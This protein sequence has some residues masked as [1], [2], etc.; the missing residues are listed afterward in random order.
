LAAQGVDVALLDDVGQGRA[1][2]R[3]QETRESQAFYECLAAMGR[4]SLADLI[5]LARQE[6]ADAAARWR[7]EASEATD[8]NQR[9]VAAALADA[10]RSGLSPVWPMFRRAEDAAG[11]FVLLEGTARRA[12]RIVVDGD[13]APTGLREYYEL[14]LF[15]ADSDHLPV[16][17]CAAR[18]PTGFP[19]GDQ[20]RE[21][22]R[23]A[24]VFFKRWAYAR[25]HSTLPD[26]ERLPERLA[27]PLVIAS[28]PQWLLA[29][30]AAAPQI[31]DVWVG[32]AFAAALAVVWLAVARAIRA[33]R[34]ARTRR[35]GYD[36]QPGPIADSS[37]AVER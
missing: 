19:T 33:D 29:S 30:R 31:G 16:I 10:S 5:R 12:V 6:V 23:V 26:H 8:E 27:V 18:L 25:R 17:I 13:D 22:V 35:S 24:G 11:R 34:L 15:T 4:G 14:D 7:S 1:F 20:I 3:S 9:R 2:N 28:E 37:G 32:L 36:A 21:P